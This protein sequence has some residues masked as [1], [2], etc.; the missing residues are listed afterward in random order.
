FSGDGGPAAGAQLSFPIGLAVDTSGNLF[1]ADGANYRIRKVSSGGIISTVAGNG[2]CCYS[3]DGSQATDA[4]LVP[5][6]VAIDS[7]GNLFVSDSVRIRRI[8][9]TGVISTVPGSD[10][11]PGWVGGLA[12][13]RAGNLFAASLNYIRKFSP[14]G[15]VTTVAGNSTLGGG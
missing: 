9:P 5:S 8:T 12:V 14:A 4:Q 2:T 3:G 1:I 7:D 11:S 6:S 13:D 10:K 15:T